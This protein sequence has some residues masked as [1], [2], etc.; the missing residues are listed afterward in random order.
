MFSPASR[1]IS[2]SRVAS[3]AP[4][5]PHDLKSSPVPPNVPVPRLSAGTLR[6][7]PPSCLY[8]MEK[9]RKVKVARTKL[10]REGTAIKWR[11]VKLSAL[12][13]DRLRVQRD[14]RLRRGCEVQ[15][16]GKWRVD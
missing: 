12:S 13:S 4:A 8:S 9:S 7:D 16:S 15:V 1:Q 2:T 3:P 10:G 5:F 11:M 14:A 6:P